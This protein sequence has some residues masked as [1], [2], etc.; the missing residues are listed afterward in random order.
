MRNG[1]LGIRN[2]KREKAGRG[3]SWAGSLGMR[4]SRRCRKCGIY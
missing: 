3:A 4:N 1:K 2:G